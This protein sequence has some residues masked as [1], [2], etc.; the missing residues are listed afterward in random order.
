M[1][2]AVVEALASNFKDDPDTKT[3]LK[4][5]AFADNHKYVREFAQKK[6]KELGG[7]K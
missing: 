2:R 3:W 6:L 7:A 1:R 4:E 5:D